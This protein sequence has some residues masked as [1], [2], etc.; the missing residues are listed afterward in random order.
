MKNRTESPVVVWRAKSD[1]F[2]IY[3]PKIGLVLYKQRVYAA[4]GRQ[5]ICIEIEQM[6][7]QLADWLQID[8]L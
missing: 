5:R 8:E 1:D 6:D 2:G 3:L 4:R 7:D